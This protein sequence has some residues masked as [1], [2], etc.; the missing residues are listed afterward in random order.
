MSLLE[1]TCPRCK[2]TTSKFHLMMNEC[3][4]CINKLSREK[5]ASEYENINGILV[6]NPNAH[7]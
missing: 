4:D 1:R 2:E 6:K 7:R 5:P 3:D